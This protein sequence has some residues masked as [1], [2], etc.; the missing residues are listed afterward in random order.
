MRSTN[1]FHRE[2]CL[3][4][5]NEIFFIVKRSYSTNSFKPKNMGELWNTAGKPKRKLVKLQVSKQL[6]K[7][8]NAVIFIKQII[9]ILY[10]FLH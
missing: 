4:G 3:N 5:S 9:N 7:I 2:D 6:W 8:H 1:V 10:G